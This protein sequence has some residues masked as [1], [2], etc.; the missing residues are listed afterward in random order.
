MPA[1]RFLNRKEVLP[2]GSIIKAI[3]WKI[4]K[5]G[6]FS[7]GIK[8]AFAYINNGKRILGCD[9]ERAKGHHKHIVDIKTGKEVEEK[10][11]FTEIKSL[12]KQF[13]NEVAILRKQLYGGKN[14]SKES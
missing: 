2:D 13:L 7:E 10:I 5:S 14:E 4:P 11:S 3:T 1:L 6:D 9:N 12:F 8:Y